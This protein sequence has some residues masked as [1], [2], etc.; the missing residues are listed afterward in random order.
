MI[1]ML[2]RQKQN[3][4]QTNE[5]RKTKRGNQTN[6]LSITINFFS[7]WTM[8]TKMIQQRKKK[9]QNKSPDAKQIQ[10][11]KKTPKLFK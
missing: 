11:N 7:P 8:Q 4:P 6:L 10:G 1:M 9:Q 3:R 2:M 5:K